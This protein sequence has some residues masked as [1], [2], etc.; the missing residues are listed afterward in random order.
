VLLNVH[1]SSPDAQYYHSAISVQ[2][3]ESKKSF[4]GKFL[5]RI[6]A[7]ASFARDISKWTLWRNRKT[8]SAIPPD[9]GGRARPSWLMAAGSTAG[10]G[11]MADGRG[12][13][14]RPRPRAAR[15]S[16]IGRRWSGDDLPGLADDGRP[17]IGGHR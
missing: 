13:E 4:S 6:P 7:A 11:T 10:P 2:G 3:L 9:S 1:V 12:H 15:G 14:R 5:A 17:S 8:P 16:S